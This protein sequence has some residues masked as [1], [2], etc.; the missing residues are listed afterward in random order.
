VEI[1]AAPAPPAAPD[2][3]ETRPY[4]AR[5]KA[6][7]ANAAPQGKGRVLVNP[8][9]HEAAREILA[10]LRKVGVGGTVTR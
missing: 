8:D 1:A 5:P 2:D 6:F 9:P 3:S 4:R 7:A 10:F